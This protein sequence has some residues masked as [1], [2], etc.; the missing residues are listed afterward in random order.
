MEI[1]LSIELKRKLEINSLI[2]RQVNY[3]SPTPSG[4]AYHRPPI[5]METTSYA[6]FDYADLL[7]QG[8]FDYNP[9]TYPLYYQALDPN[10]PEFPFKLL[11]Q[12]IHGNLD[13]FTDTNGDQVYEDGWIQDHLTGLEWCIG[14]FKTFNYMSWLDIMSQQPIIDWS[15]RKGRI[16]SENELLSIMY[17]TSSDRKQTLN[18][19]PFN[20]NLDDSNLRIIPSCNTANFDTN[21]V[22]GITGRKAST[23]YGFI[24]QQYKDTID[25]NPL[26]VRRIDQPLNQY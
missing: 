9:P 5:I 17:F 20:I 3:I 4:I 8:A 6:Q 7:M 16:P 25:H 2:D 23:V 15:G 26:Y 24:T 12:N 21:L 18:Y 10:S 22:R 1:S 14:Y 19:A 11:Y 13:R